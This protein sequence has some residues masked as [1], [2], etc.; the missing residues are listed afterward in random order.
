[1]KS[2]VRRYGLWTLAAA[3]IHA[4]LL[5]GPWRNFQQPAAYSVSPEQGIEV[6]IV[7]SA[8]AESAQAPLQVN[9]ALPEPITPPPI[10]PPGLPDPMPPPE[11]AKPPE[12]PSEVAKPKPLPRVESAKNPSKAKRA[13]SA[14][15]Q[16][17][18]PPN[19]ELAPA[20]SGAPS[21]SSA[22]GSGTSAG[23]GNSS[24]G[25]LVNPHPPYPP[26]SK[27]RREQGAVML[28]VSINERGEVT[29]ISISQSSGFS[30]LDQAARDGVSHWRFRPARVAGVPVSSHLAVPVRFRLSE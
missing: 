17:V 14:H 10:P 5:F 11:P 9:P 22:K 25:Y 30:R 2:D 27:A 6:S 19:S 3:G 21:G 23:A 16:A 29:A 1:M 7:E 28:A 15:P 18:S 12:M 24:P 4:A 8:P 20:A 26:E 13:P